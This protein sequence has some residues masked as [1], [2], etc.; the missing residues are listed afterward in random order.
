ML[1]RPND[2]YYRRDGLIAFALCL[3]LGSMAAADN[4]HA[5]ARQTTYPVPTVS[6]RIRIR[7]SP[8]LTRQLHLRLD[9][10]CNRRDRRN[11]CSRMS[12]HHGPRNLR[13]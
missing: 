10:A 3:L 5:Q 2:T 11:R 6:M 7:A 1:R 13:T 12:D 9:L 8:R 4:A